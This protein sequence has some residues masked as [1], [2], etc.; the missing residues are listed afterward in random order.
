MFST[1][2]TVPDL[3]RFAKC[4]HPDMVFMVSHDN[5][6]LTMRAVYDESIKISKSLLNFGV[7]H[8]TVFAENSPRHVM[9]ILGSVFAGTTPSLLYHGST[10]GGCEYVIHQTKSKILFVDTPERLDIAL[11]VKEKLDAIVLLNETEEQLPT[12]VYTWGEFIALGGAHKGTFPKPN[13]DEC[14]MIIYTSGTTGDPKGVML[15]HDNL[16][17]SANA[18]IKNNPI[19]V[20]ES[21]RFVSHLPLCHIGALM[22]DVIVPLTCTGVYNQEACVYFINSPYVSTYDLSRIRP[23]MIFCVPRIWERIANAAKTYERNRGGIFHELMKK[24][25]RVSHKNRFTFDVFARQYM[26]SRVLKSIGLDKMKLALTGGAHT[27][28]ELLEYFGSI[29]LDI[30]GA[31][32]MS[33]LMGVQT[34]SRPDFF[35]DGYA[36]VPVNDTEVRVDDKTGELCF[37]GRQVT[38]GYY[39][40]EGKCVDENGWFHTGDIGEI[41]ES[42]HIRILGRL[43]DLIVTSTGNKIAPEP[44]EA[45]LQRECEDVLRV[46]VVGHNEKYICALL[47]LTPGGDISRVLEGVNRYNTTHSKSKNEIIRRVA[48]IQFTHEDTTPSNK[49]KRKKII[50]KYVNEIRAMYFDVK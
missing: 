18:H 7:D 8:I 33:E 15:S 42:G 22:N 28:I 30:L 20:S 24:V 10:L 29:G 1:M 48:M 16:T 14:C 43:D 9:T 23:T 44:I 40:Q 37:R 13:H 35:M 49:I 12:N 34:V 11:R 4:R 45:H 50:K 31:Y 3:V 5:V 27:D 46:V 38:L 19:L 6:G 39:G 32:G 17:F 2:T 36:G 26:R 41:H 21:M 47:A 25:C